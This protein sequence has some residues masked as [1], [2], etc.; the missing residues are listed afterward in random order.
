MTTSKA[1]AALR[2][3]AVLIC[4]LGG[5]QP[6]YSVDGHGSISARL[7]RELIAP[8]TVNGP[9]GDLFMMPNEDG[10]FPGHSQT[11]RAS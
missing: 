7:V 3:G 9:Q 10:L 8:P 11:W 2:D 1:K 5:Q 4:T 6:S